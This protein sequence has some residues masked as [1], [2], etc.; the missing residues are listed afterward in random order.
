MASCLQKTGEQTNSSFVTCCKFSISIWNILRE[1]LPVFHFDNQSSICA[2]TQLDAECNINYDIC[3]S[4]SIDFSKRSNDGE[5][6]AAHL[7]HW[8][9]RAAASLM[10]LHLALTC[11]FPYLDNLSGYRSHFN[12]RCERGA[13][14]EPCMHNYIYRPT[15][16]I[17]TN[18]SFW[19]LLLMNST[20]SFVQSE[21]LEHL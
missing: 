13:K 6:W 16:M 19:H 8:L 1:V 4:D 9:P 17:G 5:T 12:T 18:P 21:K 11:V 15:L 14:D 20:M 10:H 7:E 3:P 2:A